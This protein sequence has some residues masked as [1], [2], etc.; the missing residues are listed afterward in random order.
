MTRW[1]PTLP[2]PPPKANSH[3]GHYHR[4]RSGV[5]W[6][7]GRLAYAVIPAKAGIQSLDNAFQEVFGV[8]SRFRG[9]DGVG[10]QPFDASDA[11]TTGQGMS[12]LTCSADLQSLP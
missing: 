11:T 3:L 1:R 10:E 7:W 8:D 12:C 4:P 9:N 5:I 2:R 6:I